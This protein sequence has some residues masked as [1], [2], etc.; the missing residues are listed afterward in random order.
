MSIEKIE[1]SKT[2]IDWFIFVVFVLWIALRVMD[3]QNFDGLEFI[4]YFGRL[5][6][7]FGGVFLLMYYFYF[8]KRLTDELERENKLKAY[9]FSWIFTMLSA[10]IF[11]ILCNKVVLKAGFALELL[12]WIGYLSYFLSFKFLDAGLDARF[13]IKTLKVIGIIAGFCGS[14]VL[15]MNFGYKMPNLSPTEFNDHIALYIG[16]SIILI[17]LSIIIL[18]KFVRMVKNDETKKNLKKIKENKNVTN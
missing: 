14:V 2:K 16:T 8:S 1:R 12:L 6:L 15:G 4:L 7:V 13:K 3:T 9:K 10:I 5:F 11:F 18:L 17:A